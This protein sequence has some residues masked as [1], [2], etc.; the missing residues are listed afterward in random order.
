MSQSASGYDRIEGDRYYTPWWC[1]MA[2]LEA[3]RFDGGIWDPAAGA[4]DIVKV[5]ATRGHAYGTDIDPDG[6][7]IGRADF[8][9]CNVPVSA[10]LINIITNP[11]YGKGGRLAV[12]FIEHALLLTERTGGKVA[13]LLRVDF[14]SANG[15]RALFGDHPAFAAKHVLTKRVRWSNLPQKSSGPTEN[16]AWYVWDWKKRRGTAPTIGYLPLA[17]A[18]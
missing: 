6:D 11:A 7:N 9:G 10:D 2:L 12:R 17:E 1:T 13:M 15:R 4:G 3:E 5:A 18:A 8:F 14:D 16:H